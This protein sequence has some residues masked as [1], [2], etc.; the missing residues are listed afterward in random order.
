MYHVPM[1]KS[2]A[3]R[4]LTLLLLVAMCVAIAAGVFIYPRRVVPS[5]SDIIPPEKM[6]ACVRARELASIWGGCAGS[7]FVKNLRASG[8]PLMDDSR[9]GS[10]RSDRIWKLLDNPYWPEAL[11]RDCALALY[12]DKERGGLSGAVWSRVG[13]KARCFQL[14]ELGR[15]RLP[16]GGGRKPVFR[17][18][19]RLVVATVMDR[20]R[21][22]PSYSYALIGD[23][24]IA[25]M[26]SGEGFWKRVDSLVAGGGR[27]TGPI[28]GGGVGEEK[29]RGG[30]PSG[31]FFVDLRQLSA[32]LDS[33][34]AGAGEVLAALRDLRDWAGGTAGDWR[35]VRGV[36]ELK[37]NQLGTDISIDTGDKASV[38]DGGAGLRN[39]STDPLARL[40]ERR[41]LLYAGSRYDPN[42]LLKQFRLRSNAK[43]VEFARRGGTSIFPVDHFSLSWLGDDCSLLIYQD[44]NGMVNAAASLLVNDRRLARERIGRFIN[45]ARGAKLSLTGQNGKRMAHIKKPIDIELKRHGGEPYCLVGTGDPIERLYKTTLALYG[46]RLLIAATDS[47]LGELDAAEAPRGRDW[48]APAQANFVMR[49][50]SFAH[51]ATS[52]KQILAILAPFVGR[53]GDRRAIED[54]R[55]ILD[56][57]ELLAPVREAWATAARGGEEIRVRG[58]VQFADIGK[59]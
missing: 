37:G 39:I 49:G 43:A 47:I 15:A 53:E 9:S 33:R 34:P 35:S 14:W 26:G 10:K 57:M 36:F 3:K 11:G 32:C 28:V 45:L 58:V 20:K 5:M 23:L 1:V 13:F 6:V 7:A 44:E 42:A 50:D 56:A 55:R 27:G 52:L 22:T 2:K 8:I 16:F 24:G 51:A 25:T 48:A 41:G 46:D 29:P 21:N 38:K 59:R 31:G 4:V 30:R 19:G 40:M 54:I 12:L 18:E 17:R